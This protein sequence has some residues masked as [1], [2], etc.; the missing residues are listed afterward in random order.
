MQILIRANNNF[1][2]IDVDE[3]ISIYELK[4]MI[5]KKI[6]K[7]INVDDLF[8]IHGN[9]IF[10]DS[11]ALK[12][13]SIQKNSLITVCQKLKGGIVGCLKPSGIAG[14]VHNK[15]ELYLLP[16]GK[17]EKRFIRNTNSTN[18]Y[19]QRLSDCYA[20]AA[21]SAYINTAMRISGVKIDKNFNFEKCYEIARYSED[22]GD[23]MKSIEL[24]ENKYQL[25]ILCEKRKEVTIQEALTLSVIVGFSTSS[26]GWINVSKGEL[27][28]FPFGESDSAH[29]AFIDGYDLHLDCFICKNSWGGFSAEPRFNFT[30]SAAHYCDFTIVYFTEQSIA[31]KTK[32]NY[33][34]RLEKFIG[35]SENQD[36]QC[37]W[38][39]EKTAIYDMNY[40][41]EYHQEHEG[42]LKYLGYECEKWIEINL[43]RP[44]GQK[45]PNYYYY[46]EFIK[47]KEWKYYV[48]TIKTNKILDNIINDIEFPLNGIIETYNKIHHIPI[49][50]TKKVKTNRDLT[51]NFDKRIIRKSNIKTPYIYKG[52]VTYAYTAV[53]AYLDT[54]NRIYGVKCI[55]S[56]DECFKIAQNHE[57]N[58][59]KSIKQLENHFNFGVRCE[60][61]NNVTI[62]DACAIS[63]IAKITTCDIGWENIKKG[64]FLE[65]VE[66]LNYE[67]HFALVIGY[68]QG[69]DCFIC[70]NSWDLLNGKPFF[71]YKYNHD[72][73][74]EFISVFFTTYSII[75]K[76]I[77][78][79]K[80]NMIRFIGELKSHKIHCAW[81]DEETSNYETDYYIVYH[82]ERE[83]DLKYL[84]YDL[85]EFIKIN[86]KDNS[87]YE[88]RKFSLLMNVN[89]DDWNS[90]VTIVKDGNWFLNPAGLI[91]DLAKPN[92]DDVCQQ[93][94]FGLGEWSTVIDSVAQQGMVWDVADANLNPPSGTPFY[95][96][97][98]HGRH[99]QH[100]IFKGGKIISKENGLVVT[101]VGGDHPFQMMPQNSSMEYNQTFKICLL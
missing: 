52:G 62:R 94:I 12:S 98:F 47:K 81:M 32:H 50:P 61:L 31:G 72:Q 67:T 68:D 59:Y 27:L 55:P 1:F 54:I 46:N 91:I 96:F 69:L 51:T 71:N 89:G 76:T 28:T 79:Y 56:F 21:V 92:K 77:K 5:L 3:S 37:A 4:L 64:G 20:Y 49:A 41:C 36:I 34:Q 75:G 26:Q 100:F 65:Y 99:N 17:L 80:P 7:N 45:Y 11:S 66:G 84:G 48:N 22:G 35:K 73:N 43:N 93:F 57:R 95:F 38:M 30:P 39:D 23:E 58:A 19:C 90:A 40:F 101:Y 6:N 70:K 24:L 15:C 25:G 86:S 10:N 13:Y 2:S 63:I 78:E 97:P 44:K 8:L 83:G 74:N 33:T 16:I 18:V 87:Q 42:E 82:P 85:D 29:A 9:D 53:C 88:G 60:L 14:D